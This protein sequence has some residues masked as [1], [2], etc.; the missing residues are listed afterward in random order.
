M[1]IGG[2]ISGA[3]FDGPKR[4]YRYAI[5]RIWDPHKQPFMFNGLN[6]STAA[7]LRNDPTILRLIRF[8]KDWG[9]GGLYGT[10]L[11]SLVSSFPYDLLEFDE[12]N[13]MNDEAIR[14]VCKLCT[15]RVV[16]WGEYGKHLKDRIEEVL[17]LLGKPVYCLKINKSGE[18]AHPLYLLWDTKLMEYHREV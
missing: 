7:E 1:K 8:G 16:G 5:W 18:P 11:R 4:K 10:N 17:G 14:E 3:L 9:F 6:P 12:P 15:I 2:S 13:D